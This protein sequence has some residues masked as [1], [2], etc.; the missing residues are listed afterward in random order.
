MGGQSLVKRT[1]TGSRWLCLVWLCVMVDLVAGDNSDYATLD[2]SH[3][4]SLG[5]A[6]TSAPAAHGFFCTPK[7][8]MKPDYAYSDKDCAA[9]GETQQCG[10]VWCCAHASAGAQKYVCTRDRRTDSKN[11]ADLE[12]PVCSGPKPTGADG[13]ESGPAC[14]DSHDAICDAAKAYGHCKHSSY[15]SECPSACG[16]CGTSDVDARPSVKSVMAQVEAKQAIQKMD[17]GDDAA[18][19]AKAAAAQMNKKQ[20]DANDAA[21]DVTRRETQAAKAKQ[22]L[23]DAQDKAAEDVAE[24]AASGKK[25]V[26]KVQVKAKADLKEADEAV[27]NLKT[28][29]KKDMKKE[30]Q[31][32]SKLRSAEAD[33]DG[34]PEDKGAVIEAKSKVTQSMQEKKAAE[35]TLEKDKSMGAKASGAAVQQ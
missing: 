24:A 22:A 29:L 13:D 27:Q 30:E 23:A 19:V 7:G 28:E 34:A 20:A 9:N 32:E 16:A 8:Q 21:E 35:A 6:V 4:E 3:D 25:H 14:Q 33:A 18:Q 2:A 12:K 1:M 15:A 10:E 17:A 5:E 11:C 31:T 26:K